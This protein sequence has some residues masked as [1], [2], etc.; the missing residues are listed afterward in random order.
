VRADGE[1][2]DRRG[3]YQECRRD[4][5]GTS[6]SL[7][8]SAVVLPRRHSHLLHRRRSR[9]RWPS[10]GRPSVAIDAANEAGAIVVT[11]PKPKPI[12]TGSAVSVLSQHDTDRLLARLEPLPD[13]GGQPAP[14][15]PPPVPAPPSPGTIQPIAFATPIGKAVTNAPIAA[16]VPSKPLV[17]PS[18]SP[19]AEVRAESEIRIRFDEPMIAV[20]AVGT[21]SHPPVSVEPAVTGTWRW[22]DTHVLQLT[23]APRLPMATD[24]V[25]TVPTGTRALSGAMLATPAVGK[26]STPPPAI[27]A[28]YPKA[29]LRPD[30][31]LAVVFDQDI[32]PDRIAPLLS[33]AHDKTKIAV[34]VISLADAR[35]LWAKHPKLEPDPTKELGRN[36]IIV[37]PATGQWPP[38]WGQATLAKGAPSREGPRVSTTPSD[39]RFTVAGPFTFEGLTCGEANTPR[40]AGQR[41]PINS[42]L[43]VHFSNAIEL[44]SY[45]SAKVQ[46]DGTELQDVQPS[47][48]NVVLTVPGD[49][50]R[51]HGVSIGDG[52]VDEY[53][54][55]FAGGHHATFV[56]TPEVFVTRVEAPT[57]LIVLDPRFHIPQWEVTGEALASMRVQLYRVTPAD[58]FAYAAYER[59][60]RATPPGTR[61]YANDIPIGPRHGV[62]ARVDLRPA[63]SAEGLGHVIAIATYTAVRGTPPEPSV[64]WIEVTKLGVTAR[65]DGDHLNAWVHDITPAR[66]L[67][68][69][70]DVATSLVV[71]GRGVTARSPTAADGHAVFAL[72]VAPTGRTN[73]V[74]QLL[75][76]TATDSTFE[77]FEGAHWRANRQ[78]DARWYVTDDRFTYK[79]GEPLYIKGWLR[80]SDNRV[81]PDI[82]VPDHGDTVDYVLV[83]ARGNKLAHGTS[84]LSDVGGF[85]AT[86]DIPANAGLGYAQL[87]VSSRGATHVHPIAIQE[88]RRPAFSVSLEDDVA[89]AGTKPLVLGDSIEMRTEAKY[90]A[91]GGLPGGGVDW[92]AHLEWTTYQPPGWERFGFEPK[93]PRRLSRYDVPAVETRQH[94]TLSGASTATSV[95][96]MSALPFH[97]PAVLSVDAN[98]TDLDRMTIRASSRPILVHPSSYYV[99]MREHPGS[100]DQLDLIVTDIDGAAVAG[101]PIDVAIDGVLGS[102]QYRDDAKIV[103][104]QHCKLASAGAPV[105]CSFKRTDDKLAYTATAVVAAAAP[106]RRSMR[107][108]GTSRT[109][110]KTISSSSPI[111]ATTSRVT[112]RRSRSAPRSC[113]PP[114]SCRSRVRA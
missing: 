13:L 28:L 70:S 36:A 4:C 85:D 82:A 102:E 51:S 27:R 23:A 108:R 47:G 11:L 69:Q 92:V 52:L 107:S 40:I 43:G 95:F 22:I 32:D 73:Q 68:P 5:A 66:F 74:S 6:A 18:I 67:A 42:W 105:T 84:E 77:G 48:T 26:F 81:N 30:S 46:I 12:A 44:S 64:V 86:I 16:V 9:W 76:T 3:V 63:L 15:M 54:Q 20:A 61:V 104:T 114:R 98:V 2:F 75:V 24:F 91:G 71:D 57:G 113:P 31:P 1:P 80:W 72:A 41:C 110:A 14:V 59:H 109:I 103:E 8:R 55:P 90:Y 25:V 93:H 38:G 56:T 39:L 97:Q 89:F 106:T 111:D 87:T 35:A 19:S 62:T 83:D 53:G 10:E 7:R 29:T 34:K 17:A 100:R 112:S 96:G 101:V 79:P 49:V 50:G 99:G 58:Y 88:F 21:A 65:V 94:A 60:E 78:R 33:F 45:R 37:V